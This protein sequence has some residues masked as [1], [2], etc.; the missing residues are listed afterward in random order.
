MQLVRGLVV[1]FAFALSQISFAQEFTPVIGWE[2]QLFPSYIISTATMKPAPVEE[3]TPQEEATVE[4]ANEDEAAAEEP[5]VEI[6]GK[7]DGL[8]G[9]ELVSPGKNVAVKLTITCDEIMEPSTFS[10]TLPEKGVTYQVLPNIKYKFR[11]LAEFDQATPVSMTFKLQVGKGPA[12]EQTATVMIRPINDCPFMLVYGEDQVQDIGYTFAAYVNEQHPFLDK[13]LREALDRQIVDGFIGYQGDDD[14]VLRQ[15]YALWDTLVMRDVR[16]S[17]I[18]AT[19]VEADMVMSQHVRLIEQSINNA[20]A[21]CV[22][23]SVLFASLLRKVGIE[24]FLILV[25]GHCYVGF[26]ADE[27]KDR[28]LAIET[29]ML[30][31]TFEEGEEVPTFDFLDNAVSEDLRDEYSWPSFTAAVVTGSASYAENLAKF[32]DENEPDYVRIDITEARRMGILPIAFRGKEQFEALA[33]SEEEM[34]EEESAEESEEG[35]DEE[36]SAEDDTEESED[37]N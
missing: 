24:P 17:S 20:Q 13:V 18:T 35:S 1:L 8:L 34:M 36:E 15:V 28:F 21:N 30:G 7:E 12:T 37:E 4:A 23:G 27:K 22:D 26:Y 6:L 25:P 5:V 9:A 10:G 3:E 16:Y 11:K 31:S 33:E 19:S 2:E 32:E 14:D 29:T